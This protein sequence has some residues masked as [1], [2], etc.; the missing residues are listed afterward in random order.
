MPKTQ[1]SYNFGLYHKINMYVTIAYLMIM[2]YYFEMPRGPDHL[3]KT[4]AAIGTLPFGV[5]GNTTIGELTELVGVNL[6]TVDGI[7]ADAKC[8]GTLGSS[9]P[10]KDKMVYRTFA[11]GPKCNEMSCSLRDDCILYMIYQN[12]GNVNLIHPRLKNLTFI[13]EDPEAE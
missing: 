9:Y 1:E 10:V 12:P 6:Y 11:A 4:T 8:L 7:T 13:F 2:G 3:Y 5:G